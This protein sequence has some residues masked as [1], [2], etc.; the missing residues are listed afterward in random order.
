MPPPSP[1]EL[2]T[3]I[4]TLIANHTRH[5]AHRPVQEIL[6]SIDEVIRRWLDPNSSERQE[7]EARLPE[8][9]GLSPEMIQHILPLIFQEYRANNLEALLVDEFGSLEILD[10]FVP[11]SQGQ[12]KVHGPR[13]TTHILAGNLPG[14]GLDSVLFSLVVKSATLVKVSSTEPLLPRLFARSIQE[15]DPDLGSCL[16]VVTWPGGKAD[17]EDVALTRADVV[18]ASGSDESLASIGQ[19]VSGKF[20]GYGHKVSFS[21]VAKEALTDAEEVARKAAYDVGL[22]DQQ[23]CL[24]PQL[25]YAEEGGAVTP[26][27]FAALLAQGLAHSQTVLPRGPITPDVSTVIRKVRDEAEWQALAGKDMV[28]HASPQGTDWTVIYDADPTFIPSPLYRTIR[29][30]PLQNLE[31]LSE[32]LGLWRPYLEA[33]GVAAST[34]RMITIADTLG[35]LGV[36]RICPIG[37]M[38]LPPPSWRHGGRPRV[39]DLVRWVGLE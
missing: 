15:I 28:L 4:D 24:S 20:I 3:T 1:A 37:S 8:T 19:R 39:G 18:I 6:L 26:K 31:Q 2:N 14:A 13:L 34:E 35:A 21:L 33:V 22:Y 27:D 23:G 17:V 36:S 29:V 10:H 16:V 11:S 30:K 12:K 9:T 38:Q 5:L 32:V 25:V 7:A